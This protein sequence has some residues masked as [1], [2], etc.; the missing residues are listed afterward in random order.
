MAANAVGSVAAPA[1]RAE[2]VLLTIHG[3][4][5]IDGLHTGKCN[6][7]VQLYAFDLLARAGDDLRP[8]PIHMR[9]TSS[10]NCSRAGRMGSS[11]RAVR[12]RRDRPGPVPSR[13]QHRPG[14]PGLETPRSKD[15]E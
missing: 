10:S 11:S 8:L 1:S 12:S 5:D 13:L 9:M 6:K 7:A 4:S 3:I 15:S 14:G 2:A